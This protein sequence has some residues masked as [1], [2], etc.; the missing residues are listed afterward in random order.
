MRPEHHLITFYFKYRKPVI[1]F[2]WKYCLSDKKSFYKD[3]PL[4]C[5][6][7]LLHHFK[8]IISFFFAK[9]PCSVGHFYHDAECIPCPKGTYQADT[10]LSF[11]SH[12]PELTTTEGTASISHED[13]NGK[14]CW[15]Y[16]LKM[17]FALNEK[18]TIY[19]NNNK[20]VTFSIYIR[21]LFTR[22]FWSSL[23]DRFKY[24]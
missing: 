20:L 8:T 18:T 13:C 21:T 17:L 14:T 12:C 9:V 5:F 15:Y 2:S 19:V 7:I 1:E 11:C 22:Q 6:Q 10:G 16:I 23:Y 24:F 4:P 3:I